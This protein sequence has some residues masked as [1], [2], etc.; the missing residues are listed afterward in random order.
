MT[1]FTLQGYRVLESDDNTPIGI[2]PSTLTFVTHDEQYF[3]YAR[4]TDPNGDTSFAISPSGL[5]AYIDGSA[6]GS[7][8]FD[9]P[10]NEEIARV[11]WNGGAHETFLYIESAQR[12]DDNPRLNENFTY[13]FPFGPDPLP[14]FATAG[15]FRAFLNAADLRPLMPGSGYGPGERIY[16]S[17]L[18]AVVAAG[19]AL[20]GSAAD[21]DFLGDDMG[22]A[23]SGLAGDDTIRGGAGRD[24]LD[25][26][27]GD[28]L[29]EGGAGY[30]RAVI[31]TVRSRVTVSGSAAE[32]TLSSSAGTDTLRSIEEVQFRDQVVPVAELLVT[33]GHRETGDAGG[34]RLT[35]GAGPD[36]LIGAEGA[37]SLFGYAG[38]DI[39]VGDALPMSAI[40]DIAAQIFRLYLATLGREPDAGGY[41]AWSGRV[42][43]GQIG[44]EDAA[45]S[46]VN[47]PEFRTRYGALDNDGFVTLL[48]EN[49]LGRAPDANGLANWS[50]RLDDG[51]SRAQ[52]VLGFSQSPEFAAGTEAEARS[53]AEN[54]SLPDWSDDVFRLYLATLD[55]APDMQGFGNWSGRLADGM[56]LEAVSQS[57]VNSP[58]F[59]ARYGALDNDGFV[60]LLYEN[61]LGRAPDANGLANWSARLDDG[62]SRAQV[63][64]GFSQSPEFAAG[65]KAALTAWMRGLDH[66]TAAT[67]QDLLSG[68]EGD[69]LM[70][71]GLYADEF[72]FAQGDGGRHTVLDLEPWD[73]IALEGFGYADGDAAIQKMTREGSDVVFADQ[74]VEITFTDTR[75]AAIAPDMILV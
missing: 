3:T 62:M 10:T 13:V 64:L 8:A 39:L 57:F 73:Y 48:Y 38:D 34:N 70:A 40:P 36:T 25:G 53:F 50:A 4:T 21:D 66:G 16:F 45:A 46:F 33:P 56:A 63:V 55:R 17:Q 41:R 52:V 31:G 65:T 18:P 71:G 44:L 22:E 29:L 58:E 32:L 2:R 6:V 47:S 75:L 15:D 26:G 1:V 19:E 59:R 69:N 51:M 67:A 60:T 7:S 37:D 43:E 20:L 27:P 68:G 23:F 61:V 24:T 42:F 11:R 5:K 49:V 74:G 28:D 30:D 35:G 9:Y 54:R 14:D 12:D 72:R